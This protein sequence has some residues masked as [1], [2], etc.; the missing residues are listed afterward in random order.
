MYVITKAYML[1][2]N[3]NLFIEWFFHYNSYRWRLFLASLRASFIG[4]QSFLMCP[5]LKGVICTCKALSQHG[6]PCQLSSV[7][8]CQNL[9]WP[10]LTLARLEIKHEEKI[11]FKI[12]RAHV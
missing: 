10:M 11:R 3:G 8:D 9:I 7:H 4:S 6:P 5:H 12:G 1:D 2:V